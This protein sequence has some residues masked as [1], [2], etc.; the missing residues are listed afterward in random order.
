MYPEWIEALQACLPSLRLASVKTRT[1]KFCH[2][3]TFSLATRTKRSGTST[4]L[5]EASMRIL[6]VEDDVDSGEALMHLLVDLGHET[7]L[8]LNPLQAPAVAIRFRPQVAIVDIGMPVVSGYELIAQLRALPEL[9]A[10]RYV[11]VSAY[12]G[13]EVAQRSAQ[14]GFEQHFSKPLALPELL[15]RLAS[16]AVSR[17]SPEVAAVAHAS[18]SQRVSAYDR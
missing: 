4:R 12:A 9:G 13:R 3:I 2:Q 15:K 6:I 1:A 17:P 14:A 18:A 7:Q 16:I 11:S 10:C 5:N 8:V